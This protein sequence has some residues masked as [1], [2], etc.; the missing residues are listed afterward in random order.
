MRQRCTNKKTKTRKRSMKTPQP[1]TSSES[2]VKFTAI[3][4]S[5]T[6]V[7]QMRECESTKKE[8]RQLNHKR[9]RA[10]K[11]K[12]LKQIE[13]T[14]TRAEKDTRGTHTPTLT[15]HTSTKTISRTQSP[16]PGSDLLTLRVFGNVDTFPLQFD[17]S[18]D[19]SRDCCTPSHA[20]GFFA[21]GGLHVDLHLHPSPAV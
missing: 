21:S 4:S 6:T 5:D 7:T 14:K 3:I 1:R 13:Q 16:H 10:Q 12:Q 18:L 19:A 17:T 9:S 11:N 20:V 2:P 15:H 8:R